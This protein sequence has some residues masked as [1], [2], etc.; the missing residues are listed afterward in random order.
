MSEI[1]TALASSIIVGSARVL[2][3]TEVPGASTEG[4]QRYDV[5]ELYGIDE[6]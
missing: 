3:H 2:Y 6:I 4:P 1:G 5:F